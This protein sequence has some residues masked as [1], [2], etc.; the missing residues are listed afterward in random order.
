MKPDILLPRSFIRKNQLHV[1]QVVVINDKFPATIGVSSSDEVEIPDATVSRFGAN[2]SEKLT[3]QL[4]VRVFPAKLLKLEIITPVN[5]LLIPL[6]ETSVH[7]RLQMSHLLI[8]TTEVV[9]ALGDYFSLQCI[10]AISTTGESIF[11]RNARQQYFKREPDSSPRRDNFSF[12]FES[13]SNTNDSWSC[14]F[15]QS[16]SNHLVFKIGTSTQLILVQTRNLPSISVDMGSSITSRLTAKDDY[17]NHNKYHLCGLDVVKSVVFGYLQN[18]LLTCVEGNKTVLTSTMEAGIIIY[19][20]PGCGK[21]TFLESLTDG[22]NYAD[23]D[24]EPQKSLTFITLT[25]KLIKELTDESSHRLSIIERIGAHHWLKNSV[26]Q[27]EINGKVYIPVVILWPNIDK[28]IDS[29]ENGD[30]NYHTSAVDTNSEVKKFSIVLDR[31][32]ESIQCVNQTP[33][34]DQQIIYRFCILATA[35]TIDKVFSIH[36]CRELFYRRLLVSLPDATRRYQ[37]LYHNIYLRLHHDKEIVKHESFSEDSTMNDQSYNTVDENENLIQV[38]AQLHGYTPKDL[39]RLVQ[40]TYASFVAMQHNCLEDSVKRK[41]LTFN[42]QL[43]LFCRILRIESRSYLPIN[44]SHHITSVD[45]LRWTDIGGYSE[46]KLIFRTMIQDR[47]ISA[48]K[49]NSPEAKA[50]AALL[51]RVPRGILLHGPP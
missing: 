12:S 44:I 7:Y 38:A 19:G 32:M 18:F 13:F 8:G 29:D 42:E 36:E 10:E 2:L 43:D 15:N 35:T 6:L 45:P 21:R 28:W 27:S 22:V 33:V 20:L 46:L 30:G 41:V 50:D 31:L 17:I 25:P 9:R 34:F 5:P 1:F 16:V 49:P 11:I 4:P 47:L 51:L 26:K 23:S 40:V 39:V 14:E 37:I 48:A 24:I 3:V